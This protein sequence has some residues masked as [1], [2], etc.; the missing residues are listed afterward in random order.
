MVQ[1][2]LSSASLEVNQDLFTTPSYISI[3]DPNN[4]GDFI[5]QVPYNYMNMIYGNAPFK[6]NTVHVNNVKKLKLKAFKATYIQFT[7]EKFYNN[8]L[9]YQ[10]LTTNNIIVYKFPPQIFAT[11]QDYIT[12][13][14]ATCT[15]LN[16]VLNDASLPNPN[17]LG[18]KVGAVTI[19]HVDPNVEWRFLFDKSSINRSL[20]FDLG[21][22][23][24][25]P[26]GGKITGLTTFSTSS[27]GKLFISLQIGSKSYS[28][29]RNQCT[30]IVYVESFLTEEDPFIDVVNFV[31]N[32]QYEQY[33][34]VTTSQYNQINVSIFD[35]YGNIVYLHGHYTIILELE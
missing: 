26:P 13:L 11:D 33:V 27:I 15:D 3:P 32:L 20:G 16:F 28:N 5:D 17:L 22:T 4:P 12:Y 31:E 25:I 24:I 35:E 21:A 19:N 2:I 7:N 14:N 29:I 10:N 18:D 34:D 1:L 9:T 30:F 6:L 8:S 23:E